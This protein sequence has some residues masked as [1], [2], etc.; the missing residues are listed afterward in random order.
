MSEIKSMTSSRPGPTKP[1][2][3]C[4][5]GS[6][7][8]GKTCFL[9]GLAI[10]GEPNG[11]SSLTVTPK[12]STTAATL[13]ELSQTLRR[14]EWPPAT[15][16]TTV[17]TIRIAIDSDVIELVLVDY[18][19][20]DFREALR[21]LRHDQIE[22][23]KRHLDEADAILLLFDPKSDLLHSNL[24]QD[25]LIER[26]MAHLQAITGIA[27]ERLQKATSPLRR[28]LDLGI[29]ITKAYMVESL[30]S[31]EDAK[32][33]FRH[34]APELD[35][36]LQSHATHVDYF[37]VS[38]IGPQPL[39]TASASSSR[40][41]GNPPR[42]FGY[43]ELFR[44]V[45]AR[46]RW[47]ANQKMRFGAMVA[48]IAVVA[49]GLGYLVTTSYQQRQDLSILNS[50]H[51]SV[52]DKLEATRS[53]SDPY[54]LRERSKLLEAEIS[55]LKTEMEQATSEES[56]LNLKTQIGQLQEASPGVRASG[57]K[58]LHNQTVARLEN[59][60]FTQVKDAFDQKK[61]NVD[62]LATRYLTDFPNGPNAQTIRSILQQIRAS[63]EYNAR[64]QIKAIR[65]SDIPTL[66]TKCE[67][68]LEYLEKY[69]PDP[70]DD[71]A[72]RMRRAAELG[73]RFTI[74]N[75]YTV[76]LKRSGGFRDSRYQGVRL[77]VRD[78]QLEEHL[79]AG[80]S[81]DV[82]WEKPPLILQWQAG[83]SIKIVLRD[84]EYVDEDVAW[85]EDRSPLAFRLL[86]RRQILD[87][88]A[89]NWK[90]RCDEAYIEFTIDEIPTSDW[91]MIA[92]YLEPGEAW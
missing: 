63:E 18:P 64:K 25:D 56:L 54:V 50:P 73:N 67:R 85:S 40:S 70:K 38:A 8:A 45:R 41:T 26:Q 89:G 35:R 81:R 78:K 17:L 83:E 6:E 13:G 62:G 49:L 24:T 59:L 65:I 39:S 21:T 53:I 31:R 19:G 37:A 74:Q 52:M 75:A 55:R 48:T 46:Q 15:N 27:D 66:R 11:S 86:G 61:Q 69:K 84:L 22:A 33:F 3:V 76:S 20:E 44:W 87:Q 23:L 91:D 5:L 7:G 79:S 16:M 43:E 30:H 71:E 82:T 47:R 60:R 9:A 42:P 57:L 80:A 36:R 14:G 34:H 77:I 28:H 29:V 72:V 51:R 1:I 10:V 90:D 92:E 68:I 32:L 88:F 2:R 58:D 4:I 12:D